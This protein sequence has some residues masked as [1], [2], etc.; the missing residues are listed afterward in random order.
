MKIEVK[1]ISKKF[2]ENTV[3]D[4]VNFVFENGK[5]YGLLG[6]N[7]TGKSVFQKM[8][9]GLYTPTSGAILYDGVDLNKNN[10][11]PANLRALIE[12]PSF[13]PE[14]T[15]F[16][17]LKL[18]AEIQNKISDKEI[19]DS[20][21]MVNLLKEKN[22]KFS[23]YSLGM[24]QKLGIA[25]VIM[26]DPDIMILDEPFNGIDR[27]T[28]E[29]ITDFLIEKKKEGKLIILST[30]IIDDIKNIADCILE[31]DDGKITEVT[32]IYKKV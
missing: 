29:K 2:K 23:K 1:N 4:K 9:A 8:L 14:L 10:A 12:K 7:G 18:L 21:E 22:K 17:N 31:L 19:D 20:L 24:K 6:R 27:A 16:Q 13:F 25:Q 3:I 15:G 32:D 26:E 5:I 30:H 28:V 11:Y